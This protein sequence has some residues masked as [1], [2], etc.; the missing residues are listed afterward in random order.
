MKKGRVW[1]D[2]PC[3]SLNLIFSFVVR[4]SFTFRAGHWLSKIFVTPFWK[5]IKLD[6]YKWDQLGDEN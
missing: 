1:L 6:R 3:E 4:K 5:R 2:W